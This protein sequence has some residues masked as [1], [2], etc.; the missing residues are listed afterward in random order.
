MATIPVSNFALEG[1][2]VNRPPATFDPKHDLPQGFLEFLAPL[3]RR[4]A[5]WQRSLIEER[6]QI[7]AESHQGE[8][9]THRFPGDAVRRGWRIELPEWCQDQ[10]NQMTGPADDADLVV[11][12]AQLGRARRDA[13]PGRF[14]GQRMGA[15]ADRRGEHPAGAARHADLFR[16]EAGQGGRHRAKADGHL[17]T[18][19]GLAHSPGRHLRRGADVGVAVRCRQHRVPGGSGGAEASAVLSTFRSPSRPK[20]RCGGAICFRR[21][22]RRGAGRATTSSAWRWWSR[23]RWRFRWRSFST[24]CAI[25]FWV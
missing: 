9:P 16:Q 19:A 21:W 6:K 24:T 14:H 8:K 12:D 1:F 4:F 2:Q 11:K 3:H 23:I 18:A 13:R 25:T 7:L 15:P 10:R 22:P 17:D 20:K 5:P